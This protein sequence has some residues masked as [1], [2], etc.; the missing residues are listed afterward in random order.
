MQVQYSTMYCITPNTLRMTENN[1]HYSALTDWIIYY[2]AWFRTVPFTSELYTY[3]NENGRTFRAR[4]SD[5]ARRDITFD[6]PEVLPWS[7]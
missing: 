5:P 7:I 1:V 4:K 2:V 6:W 3:W